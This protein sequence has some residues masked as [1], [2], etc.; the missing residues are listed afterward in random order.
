MARDCLSVE[1]YCYSP[2]VAVLPPWNNLP[3]DRLCLHLK[4]SQKWSR[5]VAGIR[6][7]FH[8]VGGLVCDQRLP[9]TYNATHEPGKSKRVVDLGADEGPLTRLGSDSDR[10]EVRIHKQVCL[11][12]ESASRAS[13]VTLFIVSEVS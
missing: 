8:Y 1:A 6:C 4:P 3:K 12:T 5:C 13:F 10:L 9:S 2:A 7:N 11:C